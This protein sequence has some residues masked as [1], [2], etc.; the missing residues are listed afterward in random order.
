MLIFVIIIL[1]DFRKHFGL[2]SKSLVFWKDGN[3][4]LEFMETNKITFIRENLMK[5]SPDINS[6]RFWF[7]F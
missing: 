1:D 6:S 2:D 3:P 7:I 4:S 5:M